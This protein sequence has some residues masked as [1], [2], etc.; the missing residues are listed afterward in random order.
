MTDSDEED[1]VTKQQKTMPN[2]T[3]TTFQ[4]TPMLDAIKELSKDEKSVHRKI[5]SRKSNTRTSLGRSPKKTEDSPK[6]KTEETTE[7]NAT[8]T[9]IYFTPFE[10]NDRTLSQ[11]SVKD[12]TFEPLKQEELK[13]DKVERDAQAPSDIGGDIHAYGDNFAGQLGL[14]TKEPK[15]CAEPVAALNNKNIISIAAGGE[16]SLAISKDGELYTWGSNAFGQRT[17]HF[18]HTHF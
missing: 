11:S 10:F 16:H 1:R 17:F 7:L 8:E 2:D 12:F 9:E 5:V 15:K 13:W 18:D 14:G 6:E 4:F 3:D